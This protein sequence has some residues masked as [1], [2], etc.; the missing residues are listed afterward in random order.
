MNETSTVVV[1]IQF[2]SKKGWGNFQKH[3]FE[4]LRKGNK[5]KQ[6][7][8]K[9][10]CYDK[11]KNRELFITDEEAFESDINKK[12]SEEDYFFEEAFRTIYDMEQ[13][14]SCFFILTDN[15]KKDGV[16]TLLNKRGLKL[17]FGER[18]RTIRK[19]Y[20]YVT[21]AHIGLLIVELDAKPIVEGDEIDTVTDE[22]LML[23]EKDGTKKEM[24]SWLLGD[25]WKE[26]AYC[27][28]FKKKCFLATYQCDD[29]KSE[30]EKE[31][32][33]LPREQIQISSFVMEG[34]GT[35]SSF[36]KFFEHDFQIFW[37]CILQKVEILHISQ[38]A[39]RIS[40]KK[41]IFRMR[42]EIE[43]VNR[44]YV[45]FYN[46]YDMVQCTYCTDGQRLYNNLRE[47]MLITR[48]NSDVR[49]QMKALHEYAMLVSGKVT[50][51]LLTFLSIAASVASVL[52]FLVAI[53]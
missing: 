28:P 35:S 24:V 7:K 26:N 14:S 42:N 41:N 4:Q 36:C 31:E 8:W 13:A 21:N 11:Q 10:I 46:Q 19:V 5:D 52:S 9:K 49:E 18:C 27:F 40:R 29:A 39:S 16:S 33:E 23:S 2:N 30:N 45:L 37:L 15:R 53:R 47:E 51:F 6:L 3:I 1:P 44:E 20:L 32:K 34:R 17:R 12:L 48:D 38:M 22:V 43:K 25:G 50:N